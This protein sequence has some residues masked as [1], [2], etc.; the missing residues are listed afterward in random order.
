MN[1]EAFPGI[2]TVPFVE[3][4]SKELLGFRHYRPD[5]M[6]EGKSMRDQMRFA[7]CYWHTMRNGLADPFGAPTAKMPW[8]DGTDTVDNCKRRADAFFEFL[9]K[10]RIDFYC[11]H[12]RDIAPERATL[13]ESNADLDKV[14]D[15]F[16]VLQRASGKKLL[17]G[18]ACLFAHPRYV[19]GA[20]T[21]PR[22]EVFAHAGAQ[23]KKAI[24]VTHRLGGEGYVFW[25]GREGYT[26]LLNTDMKRER[27]HLAHFLHM[28]VEF[29]KSIGFKGQ[30]YIEPKPREPSVHQYDSDTAACLA[31]LREF[32]LL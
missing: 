8:D 20:A 13:A 12:D 22:I 10:C 24:E 4:T 16:E 15:H 30:F 28:A 29:K 3:R 27:E 5:E 18:T 31:F 1:Q 32:G 17:W 6:V 19:S 9:R 11:F 21:S 14:V 25:G 26:T 7:S 2:D 23:V